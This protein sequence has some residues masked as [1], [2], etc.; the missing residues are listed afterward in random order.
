MADVYLVIIR[1]QSSIFPSCSCHRASSLCGFLCQNKVRGVSCEKVSWGPEADLARYFFISVP[2]KALPG[3]GFGRR[4]S[5]NLVVK[6][7]RFQNLENRRLR[8]A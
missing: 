1:Y 6:E 5:Q 3:A 7:L 2:P 8:E 4:I